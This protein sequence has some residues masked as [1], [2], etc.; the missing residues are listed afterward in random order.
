MKQPRRTRIK[1]CRVIGECGTLRLLLPVLSLG[2]FLGLV[3]CGN[4]EQTPGVI[5][6]AQ[7]SAKPPDQSS[8]PVVQESDAGKARSLPV[9][10]KP[11]TGD[12]DEILAARNRRIIVL[13]T[14]SRTLYF[15]DKGQERGLV[16][17]MARDV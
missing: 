15:N 6:A 16:A 11:V 17:E 9:E 4:G 1:L 3:A 8:Q 2:A 12:F 14:Y 5:A 13:V 7:A 10:S